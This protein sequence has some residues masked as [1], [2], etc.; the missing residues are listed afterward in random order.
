MAL[1]EFQQELVY[2]EKY[3]LASPC[4]R[5]REKSLFAPCF[6]WPGVVRQSFEEHRLLGVSATCHGSS[7]V[8]I[9]SLLEFCANHG[10]LTG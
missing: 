10:F 7:G 6:S 5:S 8:E 1:T 3:A 2:S 4:F 9:Y